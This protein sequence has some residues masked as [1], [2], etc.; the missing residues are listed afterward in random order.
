VAALIAAARADG[1]ATQRQIN[2]SRRR[3][4]RERRRARGRG[5][6]GVRGVGIIGLTLSG[7]GRGARLRKPERSE[8]SD[9]LRSEYDVQY[10]S[11]GG[12]GVEAGVV[13][14]EEQR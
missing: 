12:V 14:G 6:G 1:G 3:R 5:G 7:E 13:L 2:A 11:V 4:G 10:Q 9:L 8:I